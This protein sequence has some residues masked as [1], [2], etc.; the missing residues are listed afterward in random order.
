MTIELEEESARSRASE[1]DGRGRAFPPHATPHPHILSL[2]VSILV[3]RRRRLDSGCEQGSGSLPKPRAA[4][5]GEGARLGTRTRAR[6][7]ALPQAQLAGGGSGLEAPAM[8]IAVTVDSDSDGQS[9]GGRRCR[10]RGPRRGGCCVCASC[11]AGSSSLPP[12]PPAAHR[13]TSPRT[14]TDRRR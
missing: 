12:A 13:C 11:V 10:C 5:V 4:R 1:P 2:V 8:R 7:S 3:C 9:K 6:G 14:R